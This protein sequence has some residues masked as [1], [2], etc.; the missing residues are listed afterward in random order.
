MFIK[1][2]MAVARW[3]KS[4]PWLP[5]PITQV[6]LVALLTAIINYPNFYMKVQTSELVSNLFVE[7]SHY[8]EMISTAVQAP[9]VVDQA[10]RHALA[11]GGELLE[12]N[13]GGKSGGAA[14]DDHHVVLH[15]FA[16]AH[17]PLVAWHRIFA[18]PCPA[19]SLTAPSMVA[20]NG[21]WVEMRG[22]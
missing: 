16:F 7:C 10:M 9:R 5:G 6:V 20:T 14:A 18:C 17:G 21:A 11:L 19:N 8:T 22:T 15:R 12:P 3:K 1:A 2:N 13:R 4:K